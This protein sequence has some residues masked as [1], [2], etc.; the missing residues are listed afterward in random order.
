MAKMELKFK[1]FDDL[2]KQIEEAGLRLKPA[3]D[4]A[5]M[6]SQKIIQKA[7]TSAAA[8]YARKGGGKGYATGAMY[9]A[10]LKNVKPE[11]SGTVA[12]I[13]VGFDLS[14]KG[15]VHSIFLM[16]GTAKHPPKNQYGSPRRAGAKDTK[17]TKD[18]ALF[19]A[20]F[21]SRIGA[22][23]KKKQEEVL[24]EYLALGGKK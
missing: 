19:D 16:H 13:K 21:G 15:G 22:E 24:R 8:P 4:E 18:R 11:W 7:L 9:R 14:K 1:G 10:L 6:E 17:V 20:V 23:I 2:T 3:V 5:L 12:T